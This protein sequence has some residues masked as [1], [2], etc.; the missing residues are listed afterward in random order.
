LIITYVRSLSKRAAWTRSGYA[1]ERH[2]LQP[3]VSASLLTSAP[4]A[5]AS[6]HGVY[7]AHLLLEERR[8]SLQVAGSCKVVAIRV[9]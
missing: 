9:I 1:G 5:C 2:G 6:A 8:E 7:P 4:R 3:D